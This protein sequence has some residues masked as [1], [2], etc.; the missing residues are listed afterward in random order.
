MSYNDS[1]ARRA[2][3]FLSTGIW[4]IRS[5]NLTGLKALALNLVRVPALA[6]KGYVANRCSER[7][8]S[9]TY[10]TIMSL[11]PMLAL[12]L[13][14][15]KGFGLEDAVEGQLFGWFEGQRE[16]VAEI[17]RMAL[18]TLK[19]AQGGVIAGTGLLILFWSVF[20]VFWNMEIAFNAV[21]GIRENRR[22]S[23]MATDYLAAGVCA[24]VLWILASTSAVVLS[25][26]VKNAVLAIDAMSGVSPV[27]VRMA[28]FMPY[29][30]IWILLGFLYIFIPN[31]RIS[32][33]A[34]AVAG[35]FAG[36][37][38]LL[39]Q[40]LYVGLQVGVTRINAVYGSFAALPLLLLW[41]QT[42]WTIVLFGAEFAFAWTH[43]GTYAFEPFMARLCRRERRV[44]ALALVH[45]AVHR[46]SAGLPAENSGEAAEVFDLP[47]RPVSEML[48]ELTAA[49]I[50]CASRPG[51]DGH[52]RY[53]PAGPPG[54][55]T[56]DKVVS[57]LDLVGE[58]NL[59]PHADLPLTR[60]IRRLL[61]EIEEAASRAPANRLLS[62]I[63]GDGTG[64]DAPDR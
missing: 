61:D 52:C 57:A 11:V 31:G 40:W 10:Y 28:G 25:T 30:V 14:I 36:T 64:P 34:G 12:I 17:I 42:S 58:K 4:E 50:L 1:L 45:R 55:L 53:T 20:R 29:G 23:R 26:Q 54:T 63:P 62:G 38:Y 59:P 39:F 33:A 15:A 43:A 47:F 48:E 46:F 16:V 18:E 49:G 8:L 44:L 35:I 7:A 2:R 60:I 22:P 13:G 21:W 24:P 6:V 27:I 9:L 56:V 5:R 32:W 51:K 37:V 19:S 41:V 3:R